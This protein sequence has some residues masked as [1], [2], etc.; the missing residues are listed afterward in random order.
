M[1]YRQKDLPFSSI[2]HGALGPQ[3]GEK[4]SSPAVPGEL[5]AAVVCEYF[6]AVSRVCL[7]SMTKPTWPL[8][9]DLGSEFLLRVEAYRGNQ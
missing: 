1:L 2:C 6:R 4:N 9:R 3:E 7:R 5:E 8:G